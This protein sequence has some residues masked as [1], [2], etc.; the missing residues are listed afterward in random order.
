[1]PRLGPR[2]SALQYPIATLGGSGAHV[3]F[4]SD[5]PVSSVAP[6]RG[7]GRGRDAGSAS[8]APKPPAGCPRSSIPVTE[9]VRGLHRWQRPS[10]RSRTASG[11][12]RRRQSPTC[13]LL[14]GRHHRDVGPGDRR[15]G[16]RGT[17][18]AVPRDLSG[19]RCEENPNRVREGRRGRDRERGEHWMTG[20]RGRS[21]SPT[22]PS[23]SARWSPSTTIDLEVQ[24]GEFLSLL[25]PSGCG[26]TTTLRMLAG[27]EQPDD[28]Y[29]PH[30]GRVRAGHPALQARR[31][32]RLPALRP[33]PPHDRRRERRL[34]PAPEAGPASARSP[35]GSARRSRWSR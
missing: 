21:S 23:G 16:D 7:A 13:C 19:L 24:A 30:L 12:A 22:S 9:A 20:E 4:G 8:T 2:R 14:V 15:R 25:G 33:V 27:F 29:D 10:R 3:S 6:L 26:K 35:T 5:W 17:W 32:H 18:V 28:G 31:Q 34:R 1:M 11:G